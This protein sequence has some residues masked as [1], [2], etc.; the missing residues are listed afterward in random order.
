MR[1]GDHARIDLTYGSPN[2]WS[3]NIESLDLPWRSHE[4]RRYKPAKYEVALKADES[5]CVSNPSW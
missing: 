4:A 3:L 1:F 5:Y 2:E